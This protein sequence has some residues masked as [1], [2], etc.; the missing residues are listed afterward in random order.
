VSR[1]AAKLDAIDTAERILQAAEAEF[2]ALGYAPA[3]LAD[4]AARAGIRRPSLL[5]H[6][7]SKEQLYR[8]VVERAFDQLG[9]ELMRP[10]ALTTDFEA[11]LDA[12]IDAFAGFVRAR[13]SLAPIIVR[14]LI[15]APADTSDPES[16]R[17]G[18]APGR[19][20]VLERVAPLLDLVEAFIRDGG[21][22]RLR[23][24]LPIRAA[25]VQVAGDLLLRSAAGSLRE[26]LW[27]PGDH[28]R[29]LARS[30]FLRDP[31]PT[32]KESPQ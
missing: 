6:F 29:A 25:I 15:E 22:D 13:P 1:P 11:R 3:R 24:G 20:I 19:A 31:D 23:P 21:S 16:G 9:R 26:P 8:A 18:G 4:I 32:P 14:E 12:I 27:G 30:L 10:I 28:S 7:P 5:Y 17:R 2:A